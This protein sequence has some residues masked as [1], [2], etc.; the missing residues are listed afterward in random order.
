MDKFRVFFS[1]TENPDVVLYMDVQAYSPEDAMHIVRQQEHHQIKRVSV[2][3]FKSQPNRP[4][5][6]FAVSQ[7]GKDWAIDKTGFGR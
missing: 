2:R 5:G 3:K 6:E 7:A 4:F 1:R